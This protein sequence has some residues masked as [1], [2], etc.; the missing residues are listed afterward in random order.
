MERECG[1]VWKGSVAR[2]GH[3]VC[4]RRSADE[5]DAVEE[6]WTSDGDGDSAFLYSS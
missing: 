5:E 4:M 2:Y 1:E 3:G 6:R